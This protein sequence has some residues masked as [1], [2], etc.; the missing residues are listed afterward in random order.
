MNMNLFNRL[1]KEDLCFPSEDSVISYCRS[2][3]GIGLN[4]FPINTSNTNAAPT[5]NSAIMTYLFP[6]QNVDNNGDIV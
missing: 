2:T 5:I 1:F 4:N 6:D 3:Y